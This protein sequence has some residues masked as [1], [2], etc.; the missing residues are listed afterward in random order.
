MLKKIAF[1]LFIA[2][3]IIQF[4]HPKK[5]ESADDTKHI[6]TLYPYPDNISKIMASACNDCHSN[7]TNYPWY[8]KIQPG[9]WYLYNHVE[10][11]RKK[12]NY[13]TFAD[14]S[15]ARQYHKLEETIEYVEEKRM[16]IAS[17]TY[18]GL[19]KDAKLTDAQ[20]QEIITWA[21]GIK[22]Q[23]KNT[24]PADSLVRKPKKS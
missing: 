12:L 21:E 8:S 13:S 1:G 17:Y 6:S 20:R 23:I 2:F 19:H 7:K 5:N 9:A 14:L 16:P 24:Y 15:I 4:F 22:T 3:I 11:G 10:G 18:L